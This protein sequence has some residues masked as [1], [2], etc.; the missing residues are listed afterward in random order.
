MRPVTVSTS[1]VSASSPIGVDYLADPVNIGIGCVVVGTVTYNVEHAFEQPPVNWFVNAN[2]SGA[3]S[4]STTNYTFGVRYVRL[5]QTGGSGSV[6]M[7]LLQGS[8]R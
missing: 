1:G 7:T 3:T 2:I 8:N 5:N 4:S 6:T